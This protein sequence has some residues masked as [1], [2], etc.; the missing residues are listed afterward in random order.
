L[1]KLN[2][3]FAFVTIAW[4][5]PGCGKKAIGNNGSLVVAS[6]KVQSGA[7]NT[8]NFNPQAMEFADLP[9]S[10]TEFSFAKLDGIKV[11]LTKVR[12][13]D[14]SS[15]GHLTLIEL[16]EEIELTDDPDKAIA[17]DYPTTW[18]VGSYRKLELFLKNEWQVKA[19]C[20]TEVQNGGSYT[21]VYTSEDA[22]KTKACASDSA[23]ETLPDDYDYYTYDTL[24]PYYKNLGQDAMVSNDLAFTIAEGTTPKVQLL[25][26]AT[27]TVACWNGADFGATP[28]NKSVGGF[29]GPSSDESRI[30]R[31]PDDT[32]AFTV[33][34]LP[35]IG[36]VTT[37]ADEELPT[38]RTFFS[39]SD[40]DYLNELDANMV[41]TETV[42]VVYNA[43]EVPVSAL[44]R[45]SSGSGNVMANSLEGFS[46][47]ETAG[48]D[49]FASGWYYSG[50]DNAMPE[51]IRNRQIVGFNPPGDY[52]TVF[53]ATVKDGDR[54]GETITDHNGGNPSMSCLGTD[55]TTSYYFIEVKR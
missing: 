17:L 14:A 34:G 55:V 39:A 22:I 48:W 16:S 9:K 2:T 24:D 21:M 28:S 36:Y 25:F 46:E 12:G 42:T 32:G 50:V 10:S 37:D 49:F 30:A 13:M 40:A 54:C 8:Q 6:L 1:K 31:W 11:T 5:A 3:L 15:A 38:A 7:L 27:N 51:F 45:N 4:L 19:Y 35:L 20:K 52:T 47:N 18:T 26:D 43:E 33:V 29:R 44:S 41:N 53:S 23:C